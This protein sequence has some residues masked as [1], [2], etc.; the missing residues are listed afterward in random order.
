MVATAHAT[1]YS[2]VGNTVYGSDG[3][4]YTSYGN[5]SYGYGT[6]ANGNSY[7]CQTVGSYTYCN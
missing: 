1:T 3:S 5:G 6:D 7:S 4:N 2:R